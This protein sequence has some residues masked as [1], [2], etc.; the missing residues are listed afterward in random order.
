MQ[1]ETLS[2]RRPIN[3]LRGRGRITQQGDELCRVMFEL[4]EFARGDASPPHFEGTVQ[5][6]GGV[7]LNVGLPGLVLELSDGRRVA[8]EVVRVNLGDRHETY[9]VR[10]SVLPLVDA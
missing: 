7:P 4:T 5:V 2:S 8:I 9:E 6:T 10:G 3:Q 1:F